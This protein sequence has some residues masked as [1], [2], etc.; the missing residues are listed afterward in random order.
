MQDVILILGDVSPLVRKLVLAGIILMLISWMDKIEVK[1]EPNLHHRRRRDL[2]RDKWLGTIEFK[3]EPGTNSRIIVALLGATLLV[4]GITLQ[5][6]E[7]LDMYTNVTLNPRGVYPQITGA[8]S[9]ANASQEVSA[10]KDKVA[11]KVVSG[12]YGRGCN[13]RIGNATSLLSN[14][15][16]GRITCDY[17]IDAA[18]LGD[19]SP[20]CGKDF[21]AEWICG[22]SIVVY[23]AALSSIT[24]KSDKLHLNCYS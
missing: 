3:I 2:I 21:G 4:S 14:T 22:N 16:D 19:S 5:F 23:S 11:I 6:I 18:V 8:A 7:T 9:P 10:D 13:A 1:H 12:T 17:S 24:G 15:C 20:N